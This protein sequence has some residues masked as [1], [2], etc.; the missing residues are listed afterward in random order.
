M[1][2]IYTTPPDEKGRRFQSMRSADGRAVLTRHYTVPSVVLDEDGRPGPELRLD[3]L[4]GSTLAARCDAAIDQHIA[5][6]TRAAA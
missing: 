3:I 4:P 6:L 2:T 1:S 5:N